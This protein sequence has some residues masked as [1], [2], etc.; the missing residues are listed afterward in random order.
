MRITFFSDFLDFF[1]GVYTS[2]MFMGA[3]HA[4]PGI[5]TDRAVGKAQIL[6]AAL[7]ELGIAPEDAVMVGDTRLDV[8]AGKANGMRTI[9][10]TWGY[11]SRAELA[12]ADEM[13]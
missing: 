8:E 5:P 7:A 9:G 4:P 11:G 1:D 2:D 12:A 13:V 3:A 6:S 10:V